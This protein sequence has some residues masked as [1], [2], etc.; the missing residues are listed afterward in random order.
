MT[1]P[2]PSVPAPLALIPYAERFFEG[3]R[4]VIFGNATA[5]FAEEAAE[6]GARL[7]HVYD[8]DGA[9]VAQAIAAVPQVASFAAYREGG[10]AGVRDGAFDV[11][12]IPDL[13]IFP[14][15]QRLLAQARRLC[16]AGAMLLAAT[17]RVDGRRGESIRG[18]SG[19]LNYY[20]FHG[21]I[22]RHFPVVKM[23]GEVPF[24][25][26]ALVDFSA[27]GD[28][29]VAVDASLTDSA[30]R[31]P[32][33]YMAVASDRRF[34]LDSYTIIQIPSKTPVATNVAPSPDPELR[35]ATEARQ[36][37]EARLADEQR[38]SAE[39]GR[40]LSEAG[41]L[42][43][44][45]EMRLTEE[46]RR[47]EMLASQVQRAHESAEKLQRENRTLQERLQQSAKA[48]AEA[49]A[50][51]ARLVQREEALTRKLREVEAIPRGVDPAKVEALRKRIEEVEALYQA[52]RHEAQEAK[53]HLDSA[54]R[55]T[56]EL[57]AQ[58]AQQQ[59]QA[60]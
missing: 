26:Y 20:D 13:S 49:Q 17:P 21:V 40:A 39:L 30:D 2:I 51:R 24:Q 44:Q 34:T 46:A 41:A 59:Q 27:E 10:D 22:A 28:L 43:R 50:E 16:S 14:D 54:L 6:R 45:L 47:A 36:Q 31:E 19:P 8:P 3:R 25:G 42:P 60:A 18:R 12:L 48:L 53:N 52:S 5:G 15:P 33:A 29:E 1:N 32:V 9:R 57:K 23:V 55:Q 7:V 11:C 4:V 35:K 58:L 56:E 37:A 38:R